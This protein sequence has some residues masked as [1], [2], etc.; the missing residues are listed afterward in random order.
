MN[1]NHNC[2]WSWDARNKFSDKLLHFNGY[3]IGGIAIHLMAKW[4]LH[5]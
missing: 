4:I 5:L 1:G 2:T 3:F